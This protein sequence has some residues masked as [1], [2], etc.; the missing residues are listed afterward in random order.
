MYITL[1]KQRK[2]RVKLICAECGIEYQKLAC[3]IGR[4]RGTYCSKACLG[5]SKR[6][7]SNLFCHLC[8][9]EFY[10]A[11]AE[12][13]LDLNKNQFCS[14]VCYHEWRAIN[15]KPGTYPKSGRVHAH[16]VVAESCLGRPLQAGEVV[17]HIDKNKQNSHPS[18]LAVFPNQSMHA[19]CH[20]GK[21][22]D[23]E[24]QQYAILNIQKHTT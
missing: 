20:F 1:M 13:D 9:T 12:Q 8:D 6:N 11:F 24:L 18:N 17:H 23:E 15:I 3:Q 10:R 14:T 16:R 21:M 2:E 7:G 19:R 22:A 4:G 5:Q